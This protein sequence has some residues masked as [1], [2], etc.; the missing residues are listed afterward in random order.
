MAPRALNL[1]QAL[2]LA[3]LAALIGWQVWQQQRGALRVLVVHSYNTDLP[4]VG[5]VD[6]GLAR[7]AAAAPRPVQLRQHYMNLLNRPDCHH[8]RLAAEDA[9]LAV[10]DWQPDVVVLVDDLA[11]ALVGFPLL[12]LD[13]AAPVAALRE[14]IVR[15]LAERRCPGQDAAFFGLERRA[16]RPA[17]GPPLPLVFAGVNGDVERY[18]YGHARHVTGIFEHKNVA[19]LAETLDTVAASALQPP[20]AVQVLNDAS[21]T[22]LSENPRWAAPH[23]GRLPWRPPRNA[24]TWAEWQDAV[25]RANDEGSMLLIANYQDLRDERG[26][27]VPP[28]RVVA[29][30]ERH[31]LHPPVGANTNFVTDGGAITLAVSG[32]EQGQVAMT[33]AL[34]AAA[35]GAMPPPRTAQQLLVG[36]NPALVRQRGLKLPAVYEAFAREIGRFVDVSEHVYG[37]TAPRAGAAAPATAPTGL[38]GVAAPTVPASAPASANPPR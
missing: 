10:E 18:G 16:V 7:A 1:L 24:A 9:R 12:V 38:A 4:W 33:L 27:L 20:R 21:P 3:A 8:Y 34:Q 15:Q 26:Q 19:A 14:G 5:D 30:T 11:Q 22:A 23:G 37:E 35:G 32:T 31:A 25:L 28:S 29:W 17:G 13:A 6:Q 36:L 2:L